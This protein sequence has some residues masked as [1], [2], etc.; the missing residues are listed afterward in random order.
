ML[1]MYRTSGSVSI[2]CEKRKGQS[3]QEYTTKFE[4]IVI[5][6]G[7]SPKNPYILLKYLGGLHSHLWKKVMSFKPR[8]IDEACVQE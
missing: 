6:L 8:A 4:E 3:V 2:T 7:I 5:M 1:G